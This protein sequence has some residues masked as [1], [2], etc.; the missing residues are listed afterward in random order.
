MLCE[1]LGSVF[2]QT[3]DDVQVIVGYCK[4]W[5]PEKINE[6]ASIAK[7]DYFA[8]LCDDDLLTPS[9]IEKTVEKAREG[10]QLVYTDYARIQGDHLTSWPS[11]PWEFEHFQ[12]GGCNPLCGATYLVHRDL[13]QAVGGLDPDQPFFDWDLAYACFK[14]GAKAAR[15]P[16]MLVLYREHGGQSTVD[17]GDAMRR[18]HTKYPELKKVA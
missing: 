17:N 8:V 16:E 2:T 3:R 6:L 18:L 5:W 1:A 11:A 10:Y 15:I 12:S 7:G 14:A 9:F 4:D 13:W